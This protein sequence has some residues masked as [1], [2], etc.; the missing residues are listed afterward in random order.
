MAYKPSPKTATPADTAVPY[1]SSRSLETMCDCMHASLSAC[2]WR[3][4]FGWQ[5]LIDCEGA[6]VPAMSCTCSGSEE[7]VLAS[8]NTHWL[9]HSGLVLSSQRGCQFHQIHQLY[10]EVFAMS[11]FSMHRV[12][13]GDCSRVL[14]MISPLLS[15]LSSVS[16]SCSSYL[17]PCSLLAPS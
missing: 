2:V 6:A 5:D 17:L 8:I 16:P 10:S 15:H 1:T 14:D 12:T 13:M 7:N 9:K 4:L 11:S 3:G